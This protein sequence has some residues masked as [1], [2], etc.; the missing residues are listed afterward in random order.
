MFHQDQKKFWDLYR[1]LQKVNGEKLHL[2]EP[3]KDFP[4]IF[5]DFDLEYNP[6]VIEPPT[7]DHILQIINAF[8]HAMKEVYFIRNTKNHLCILLEKEPHPK[9]T[10]MKFGFH[11]QFPK[12]FA[13][14]DSQKEI[15]FPTVNEILDPLFVQHG[16]KSPLHIAP[17]TGS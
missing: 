6:G 13:T 5:I 4:Q 9:G 16:W 12:F 17:I 14:K 3:Q 7:Y 15:L 2:A 8:Q 1:E 10:N 11:L